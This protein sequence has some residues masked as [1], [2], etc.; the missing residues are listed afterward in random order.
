MNAAKYHRDATVMGPYSKPNT[1][2]KLDR[3]TK[4]ARLVE[5]VR[6]DLVAHVGGAPSTSQAMII[7]QAAQLR[8]RIA[9]MDRKLAESGTLTD[10]DGRQ[11]IA[12]SNALIRTVARLGTKGVAKAAPSIA[13]YIAAKGA[14]AA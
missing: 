1:L 6:A 10:H 4:E 3:R 7:E 9:L 5:Q 8:L 2:T 13:D 14:S 11:Y 12:W